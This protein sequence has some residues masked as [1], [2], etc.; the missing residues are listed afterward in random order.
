[1]RRTVERRLAALASPAS[2][3]PDARPR[4]RS[5]LGAGCRSPDRRS[6]GRRGRNSGGCGARAALEARPP[7]PEGRPGA[8]ACVPLRL[9]I[10]CDRG[11]FLDEGAELPGLDLF[12]PLH[13]R[14]LEVE[15]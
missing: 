13:V 15:R 9:L 14:E 3:A 7:A 2:T 6:P 10:A 11:R 5:A 8:H 4:E 12:E 1:T